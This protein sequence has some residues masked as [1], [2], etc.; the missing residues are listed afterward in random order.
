MNKKINNLKIKNSK[1]LKKKTKITLQ[2]QEYEKQQLQTLE[3][4]N[5]WDNT[6]TPYFH[7]GLSLKKYK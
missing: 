1:V 5:A 4:E 3:I 6:K 2:Y 7:C